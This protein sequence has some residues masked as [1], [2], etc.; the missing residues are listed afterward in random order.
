MDKLRVAIQKE[1]NIK[2]KKQGVNSLDNQGI[3]AILNF[4][5]LTGESFAKVNP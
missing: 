2:I 5:F 3:R 4:T 1:G